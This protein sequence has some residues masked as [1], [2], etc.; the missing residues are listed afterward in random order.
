MSEALRQLTTVTDVLE[1]FRD[2]VGAVRS[3]QGL[4]VRPETEAY[5]V[6]LLVGFSSTEQLFSKDGGRVTGEPLALMLA[7]DASS[8]M[9]G[10][11]VVIDGG[12]QL[13]NFK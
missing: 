7:S 12:V 11:H 10:A 6:E 9:T 3:S 4:D 8:F 13:G 1:Y 5:L 2:T